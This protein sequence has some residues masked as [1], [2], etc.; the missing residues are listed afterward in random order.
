MAI[1]LTDIRWNHRDIRKN[2][3]LELDELCSFVYR[4]SYKVWVWLALCPETRQEV[5]DSE[6]SK[7]RLRLYAASGWKDA[8]HLVNFLVPRAKPGVSHAGA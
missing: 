1:P 5:V 2:K 7:R 8:G 6:S 4:K 3:V